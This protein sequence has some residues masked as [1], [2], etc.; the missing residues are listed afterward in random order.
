MSDIRIR[1][2]LAV[3]IALLLVLLAILLVPRFLSS[4][5]HTGQLLAIAGIVGLSLFLPL[6]LVVPPLLWAVKGKTGE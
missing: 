3:G 6:L 2:R 4:I 5:T 1:R